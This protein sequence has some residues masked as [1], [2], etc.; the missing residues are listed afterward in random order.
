MLLL[1]GFGKEIECALCSARAMHLKKFDVPRLACSGL[2]APPWSG[3]RALHMAWLIRSLA[4]VCAAAV[5]VSASG[6]SPCPAAL[7][8]WPQPKFV[9]VH[10]LAVHVPMHRT[11]HH[12]LHHHHHLSLSL[13]PPT[14][15]SIII[16]TAVHTASY[17]VAMDTVANADHTDMHHHHVRSSLQSAVSTD[18]LAAL[19]EHTPHCHTCRL[20]IRGEVSTVTIPADVA[21]DFPSGVPTD[22]IA[23]STSRLR[24]LLSKS[25][26]HNSRGPI[27]PHLHG[28]ATTS[29]T[30][31][32]ASSASS[33][34]VDAHVSASTS[35]TSRSHGASDK[36]AR[37]ATRRRAADYQSHPSER[38]HTTVTTDVP[39][40]VTSVRV[41]VDTLPV[42][43]ALVVKTLA[44]NESCVYLS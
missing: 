23:T 28:N 1:S 41:V 9:R 22:I 3:A 15:T 18:P 21:I 26:T 38:A 30:N 37:A 7:G 25:Y 12:H 6:A 39:A 13:K 5:A 31:G 44:S 43:G 42:N 36:R 40:V 4:A 33:A 27:E 2:S 24:A 8:L 11:H 19:H 29:S 14:H 35:T 32:S 16:T 10:A 17:T 34:S 20:C